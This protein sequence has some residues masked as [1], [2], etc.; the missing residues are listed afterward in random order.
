MPHL[1][2]PDGFA[3]NSELDTPQVFKTEGTPAIFSQATSISDLSFSMYSFD[4]GAN[5]SNLPSTPP[6]IPP[7]PLNDDTFENSQ[8]KRVPPAE[9]SHSG[10]A[11]YPAANSPGD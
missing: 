9:S 7:P 3:D 2:P 10:P 5:E 8:L 11:I 4:V 6:I 1:P